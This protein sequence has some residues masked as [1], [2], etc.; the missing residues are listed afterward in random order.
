VK[1][2]I[3]WRWKG[4]GGGET[5]RGGMVTYKTAILHQIDTI[6]HPKQLFFPFLRGNK[7]VT[8]TKRQYGE[9]DGRR[10][11]AQGSARNR[12]IVVP[13]TCFPA[14]MWPKLRIPRER[15]ALG[16]LLRAERTPAPFRKQVQGHGQVNRIGFNCLPSQIEAHSPHRHFFLFCYFA[17]C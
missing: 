6:Q 15:I 17:A 7:K 8:Q 10:S 2:W 4:A 5:R 13:P 16:G 3:I 12:Q 11:D 9:G 1:I 14:K